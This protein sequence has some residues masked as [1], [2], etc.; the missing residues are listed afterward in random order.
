[1]LAL[2]G[3]LQVSGLFF[4]NSAFLEK[5][6][7]LWETFWKLDSCLGAFI[8]CNLCCFLYQDIHNCMKKK[9]YNE[10][11]IILRVFTW[12]LCIGINRL[13]NILILRWSLTIV[14]FTQ[15]DRNY[16]KVAAGKK[17]NLLVRF[18]SHFISW[19]NILQSK[20]K[21]LLILDI[22]TQPRYLLLSRS[23]S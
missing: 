17:I 20:E 5:C 16:R 6:F 23:H 15:T 22:Q 13:A 19:P 12:R 4:H 14:T 8:W 2:S 18:I 21:N 9:K 10:Y 11:W 3:M 1:M 7:D